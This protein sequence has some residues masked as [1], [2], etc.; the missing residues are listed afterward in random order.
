MGLDKDRSVFERHLPEKAVDYCFDLWKKLGFN[1]KI[2]PNRKSKFG[3]YSYNPNTHRHTITVNGSLN[4]YAFLV[5]Y[6]HEVAH[7]TTFDQFQ[8][9]VNPHGQEWKHEFKKLMIPMLKEE[10]FPMDILSPLALH[11]KNPK[12]TSVS[13]P[14]LFEALGK[15]NPPNSDILLKDIEIGNHFLF[16]SKVYKKIDIKRTRALCEAIAVK[17]QYL[18]SQSAPVQRFKN[19]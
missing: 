9:K 17:K 10:V 15:Y 8:N 16:R 3:D 12:A 7:K 2:T 6:I 14:R 1:L 13:D 18:I 19:K 11:M 4:T 5:T